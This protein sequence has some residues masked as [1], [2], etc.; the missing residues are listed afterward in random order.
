MQRQYWERGWRGVVVVVVAT[1]V[2]GMGEGDIDFGWG[3]TGERDLAVAIG[4]GTGD[5]SSPLT[6]INSCGLRTSP[7]ENTIAALGGVE[8][9][10]VVAMSGKR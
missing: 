4:R 7:L 3:F 10:N 5:D 8:A 1:G 9:I 6:T 2:G